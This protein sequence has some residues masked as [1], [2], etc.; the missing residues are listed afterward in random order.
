MTTQ[1]NS[2]A[3]SAKYAQT[4]QLDSL[5]SSCISP[6]VGNITAVHTGSNP[7]AVTTPMVRSRRSGLY[8]GHFW[9]EPTADIQQA[10]PGTR[11]LQCAETYTARNSPKVAQLLSIL[12]DK[13]A[14]NDLSLN[15]TSF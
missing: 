15:L 9:L 12:L 5:T 2:S 1:E 11:A 6:S 8:W 4:V 13:P 10:G 7:E 14:Y 3:C